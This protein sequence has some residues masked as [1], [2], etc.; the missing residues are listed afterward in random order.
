LVFLIVLIVAAAVL[1]AWLLVQLA[2][3]GLGDLRP[4]RFREGSLEGASSSGSSVPAVGGSGTGDGGGES[5]ATV[6]DGRGDDARSS[7]EESELY[8]QS[9]VEQAVR[10]RLYGRY[11]R[12]D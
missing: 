6:R 7:R 8:D 3:V 4:S 9:D 5:E 10:D 1:L 2:R 12:R 11:G